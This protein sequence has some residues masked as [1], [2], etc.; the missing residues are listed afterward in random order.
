MPKKVTIWLKRI[1]EIKT[2]DD[3][4]T[5]QEDRHFEHVTAYRLYS[6]SGLRAKYDYGDVRRIEVE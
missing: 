4:D 1:D 6:K 2:H 3:I 5:V